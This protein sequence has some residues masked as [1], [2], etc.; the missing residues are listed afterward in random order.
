MPNAPAGNPAVN[1]AGIGNYSYYTDQPGSYGD[2]WPWRDGYR[3]LLEKDRWYC[4][5]LQVK[6]ND[7]SSEQVIYVDISNLRN[8]EF[9]GGDVGNGRHGS[10]P[11]FGSFAD[12][13]NASELM[14]TG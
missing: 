12:L 14:V 11:N 2:I 3:G 10:K 4:I 7:L 1:H 5:E 9:A 13:D 8:S 6:L